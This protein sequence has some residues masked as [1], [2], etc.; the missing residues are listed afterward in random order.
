MLQRDHIMKH[1]L[2]IHPLQSNQKKDDMFNLQYIEFP[3]CTT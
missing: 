2:H 1:I 3:F